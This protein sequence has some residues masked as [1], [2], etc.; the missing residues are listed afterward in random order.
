VKHV[1]KAVAVVALVAAVGAGAAG[2]AVTRGG[3]D[4]AVS[5]PALLAYEKQL[6]P[7]VQDGGRVVEHGMRPAVH[8]LQVE[9]IV[10]GWQIA[11]EGDGWIT[12]LT[13]VRRKVA[14]VSTPSGLRPA[15]DAFLEAL[16]EYV[17]AARTFRAA[18]LATGARRTELLDK[19]VSQAE[20][21]DHTYDRGS[22][23]VQG[24]RHELGLPSSPYFP[25][26][27]GA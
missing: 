4:P 9:H 2:A 17:V 10:P 20:V 7:L 14:R 11:R 16:D 26:V 24:I 23:V 18:A 19:G 22:A 1:R 12:N 3:S 8:D 13:E 15:Q 25:E 6:V 5:K 27:S 21:A